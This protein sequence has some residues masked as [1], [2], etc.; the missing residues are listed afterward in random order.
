LLVSPIYSS[1]R[2]F[3]IGSVRSE[4]ENV[5]GSGVNY[6]RDGADR[7]QVMT[8]A[9]TSRGRKPTDVARQLASYRK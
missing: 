9:P 5:V 2:A 6:R 7:E 3:R 8:V 1:T 4:Q